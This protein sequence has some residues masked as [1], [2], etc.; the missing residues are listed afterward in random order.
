MLFSNLDNG[1]SGSMPGLEREGKGE[2]VPRRGRLPPER[3]A[4]CVLKDAEYLPA[5]NVVF[6]LFH[7]C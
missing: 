4:V 2:G 1:V 6:R 5:K 3:G 7:S